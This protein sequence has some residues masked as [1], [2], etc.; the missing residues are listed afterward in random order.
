MGCCHPLSLNKDSIDSSDI[1]IP[2]EV[3]KNAVLIRKANED[4]IMP[5]SQ[6]GSTSLKRIQSINSDIAKAP[7]A[8]NSKVNILCNQSMYSQSSWNSNSESDD[9]NI[10]KIQNQELADI[11]L[12][13]INDMRTHPQKYLNRLIKFLKHFNYRSNSINI[14]DKKG[15][16]HLFTN[17][18]E[19]NYIITYL[20]K[21]ASKPN[22]MKC[23]KND[24]NAIQISIFKV[25]ESPLETLFSFLITNKEN[26]SKIYEEN[27]NGIIIS[28]KNKIR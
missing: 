23:I 16:T 28:F 12:S 22:I 18:V 7:T 2:Y 26:I 6:E 15:N 27:P 21:V 5:S 10:S 9:D 14:K 4:F 3:S 19:P 1:Y 24:N 20:E 13:I 25:L 11:L 17:C 8:L